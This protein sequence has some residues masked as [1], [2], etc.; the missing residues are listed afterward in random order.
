MEKKTS[1]L[2]FEN[3]P[4][5]KIGDNGSWFLKIE[6]EIKKAGYW[7]GGD[8]AQELDFLTYLTFHKEEIGSL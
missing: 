7:F 5:P 6:R 4:C 2:V 1:V 8:N 3:V